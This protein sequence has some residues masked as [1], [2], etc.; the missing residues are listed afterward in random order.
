MKFLNLQWLEDWIMRLV[1][2]RLQVGAWCGLCGKWYPE[3]LADVVWPYVLC[4]Q[5]VKDNTDEIP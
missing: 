5:C 3:T 1:I 2:S 4:A